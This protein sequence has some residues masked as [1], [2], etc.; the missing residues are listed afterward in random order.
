MAFLGDDET[1]VGVI[2]TPGQQEVVKVCNGFLNALGLKELQTVDELQKDKAHV[3]L[4]FV[5]AQALSALLEV[6]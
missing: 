5:K 2:V 6:S 4:K 1:V 3:F